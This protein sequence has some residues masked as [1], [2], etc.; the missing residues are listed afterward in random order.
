M[1]KLYVDDVR[2]CPEGWHLARTI[3]EA[4]R[5]L[6]TMS[7]DEVSLD[8]DIGYGHTESFEIVGE[9]FEPV[10]RYIALMENKPKVYVH[11][12]N[13]TAFDRYRHIIGGSSVS[14]S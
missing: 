1:I 3:T 6:A 10:A 5:I 14:R 7:V 4:I 2:E 9:T 8:H 12:G 11:S 13:P